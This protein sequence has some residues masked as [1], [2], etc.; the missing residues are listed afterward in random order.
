MLASRA[1]KVALMVA[2]AMVIKGLKLKMVLIGD[3]VVVVVVEVNVRLMLAIVVVEAMV[4][5]Q[6]SLIILS[7]RQGLLTRN[8][9]V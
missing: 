8:R 4:K 9:R 3:M 7:Q 6:R 2:E 1:A 5:Y